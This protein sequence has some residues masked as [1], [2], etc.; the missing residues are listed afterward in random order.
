MERFGEKLHLLRQRHGLTTRQL[1]EQLQTSNAQISR[2]ENGLRQA[3][4]DLVLKASLLFNIPLE[5][6][7]RDDLEVKD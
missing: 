6:L 3:S 1:A 4:A 2:I 5:R 7:M